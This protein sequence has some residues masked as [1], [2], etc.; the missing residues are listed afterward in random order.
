MRKPSKKTKPSTNPLFISDTLQTN[1]RILHAEAAQTNCFENLALLATAVLARNL[2]G[3]P[4]ATLNTLS[5]GYLLSRVLYN[6]V[7]INNTS[8]G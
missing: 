8:D 5:G 7:Y 3:L 4:A 2:A 1:A 6:F